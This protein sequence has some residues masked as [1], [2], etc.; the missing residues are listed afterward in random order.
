MDAEAW[1][2]TV[3]EVNVAV[4]RAARMAALY[5]DLV[6]LAMEAEAL[7]MPIVAGQLQESVA[8]TF[9]LAALA[10]QYA[11]DLTAALKA[12]REAGE[13]PS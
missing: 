3:R 7:G 11:T 4:Q 9:R 8:E 1:N 13:E 12:A 2:A 10:Q 6:R 5:A